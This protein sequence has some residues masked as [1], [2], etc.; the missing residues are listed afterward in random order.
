MVQIKEEAEAY[1]SKQT[2]NISEL[3]LV[4]IDLEIKEETFKDGDG[5]EFTIKFVE[6]NNER[7]R[8]PVSVLKNLKAIL[9]EKPDLKTFK[10]KK[11]GSGMNTEYT[12]IPI[13]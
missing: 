11:I 3:P 4:A 2:K 5:K 12:V 6:I 9:E 13:D 1:E 8:V 10:V 7:Y